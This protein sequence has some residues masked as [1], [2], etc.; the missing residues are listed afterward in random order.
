MTK[1]EFVSK[2]EFA[3]IIGVSRS[4]I[5]Q[6]AREGLPIATDGRIDLAKG[7]RWINN[8]LD[9]NRRMARKPSLSH[10]KELSVS[11]SR[12]Q[13]LL[14]EGRIRELE[15]KKE[16][17]EL[18]KRVVVERAVFERSRAERDRWISAIPRIANRLAAETNGDAT[19]LFPIVDRIVRDHLTELAATPLLELRNA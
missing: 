15:F 1:R 19:Q 11:Q 3:K 4:R 13:K 6:L 14:W 2:A 5:S 7:K 16:S 12:N 9:E 10:A 17:G 18:V 8:N